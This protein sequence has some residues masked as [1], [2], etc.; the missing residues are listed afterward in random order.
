MSNPCTV[1]QAAVA[2]ALSL[3]L[4]GS[5]AAHGDAKG[6]EPCYGISKAGQNDCS[7]LSLTHQCAG[8]STVDNDP[9]EWRYVPKGTCK[10]LKGLT[11]REAKARFKA[12]TA[13]PRK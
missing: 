2:A 4:L 6:K 9:E 3:G 1:I 5:A 10:S 13:T 8:E 11:E 12:S 7:N